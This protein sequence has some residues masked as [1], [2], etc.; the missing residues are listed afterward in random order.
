MARNNETTKRTARLRAC[1]AIPGEMQTF[2]TKSISL[3][4]M[5]SALVIA[6]CSSRSGDDEEDDGASHRTHGF[7][8]GV[9]VIIRG[10]GGGVG[11]GAGVS[12]GSSVRGGFGGIGGVGAGS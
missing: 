8:G 3:V 9:P 11:R 6:G 5:G 7:H 10:A 12:T 4:L 1:V 2:S